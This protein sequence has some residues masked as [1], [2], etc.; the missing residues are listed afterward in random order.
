MDIQVKR[1]AKTLDQVTALFQFYIVFFA[2]GVRRI[3]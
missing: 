2:H 3:L 1:A